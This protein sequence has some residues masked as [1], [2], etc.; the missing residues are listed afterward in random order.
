V[1]QFLQGIGGGLHQEAVNLF[2]MGPGDAMKFAR[3]GKR[4]QV[5]GAGQETEALFAYPAFGLVLMTLRAAAIAA[6]MI[7]VAFPVA[8]I[9]LMKMASKERRSTVCDIGQ[10]PLLSP[11]Q[12]RSPFLSKRFTMEA[13][14]IGHLQH[15]GLGI[16]DRA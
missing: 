12:R 14:D 6:G 13:D 15:D 9:A 11:G 10:G 2:R 7:R 1:S 5:V 4:Q 16:R 3:Q 8:V